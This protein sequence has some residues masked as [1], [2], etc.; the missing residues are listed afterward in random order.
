MKGYFAQAFLMVGVL[1]LPPLNRA[2]QTDTRLLQVGEVFPQFTGKTLMGKPLELPTAA[3]GK[4]A[5]VIFS[6]S[7]SAGKDAH[8]WNEAIAKGFPNTLQSYTL[9]MLESVPTLFRGMVVAGIKSNMPSVL[10]DRTIVSY[11]DEELWK[12]RLTVTDDGR[13]YVVLV[14]TDDHIRWISLGAFSETEYR[15]LKNKVI[16]QRLSCPRK[17]DSLAANLRKGK[18]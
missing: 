15:R 12:H 11:Q 18:G 10:Q 13:A 5:V 7:K 2:V 9:I 3:A 6:F 14:G 8:L 16:D 4:P 17:S 1:L